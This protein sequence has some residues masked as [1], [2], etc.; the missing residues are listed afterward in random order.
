MYENLEG[1]VR[2]SAKTSPLL[3]Q[4]RQTIRLKH[5][6]RS[7]ED[8]YLHYILDYIRYHNKRHPKELGV[9][10]IRAY[11]THLAV[12]KRVAASTQNVALSALLFL[13]KEVLHASLPYIDEIEHAKRPKRLPVVFTREE[14]RRILANLTGT[15]HLVIA[16]LYG[17]GMRLSEGLR[18][19]VKDIDFDYRQIAVRDGSD[20]PPF[21]A[22]IKLDA[23][24]IFAKALIFDFRLLNVSRPEQ[25][26]D[27][28]WLAVPAR[29]VED[30]DICLLEL[31]SR[32][33]PIWALFDTGAGLS[34][35]NSARIE[36]DAL[37]LQ[38]SFA[39]EVSDATGARAT[40]R[41]ALCSGL[42]V[43]NTLVPDFHCL[44]ID[45]QVIEK[46]LG[47]DIHMVFGANAMLRSGFSWL[48]DKPAKEVFF[49]V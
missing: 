9:D 32:T 30:K 14:V 12:H 17:T 8:S 46:A 34:V 15:H 45:L 7:T 47:C 13:Y 18:L 36:K 1:Q 20:Q 4:V 44:S 40:Q 31:A 35:L 37:D 43:G 6:S 28:S 16:L 21:V 39:L 38:P 24:T 25:R 48:I 26:A 41:V 49:A 27:D 5:Y 29:F 11:L 19:Q 10:E 22:D 2:Y 33:A 42:R 23:P 3:N